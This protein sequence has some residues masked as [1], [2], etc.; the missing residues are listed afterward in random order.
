MAKSPYKMDS[1]ASVSVTVVTV[2]TVLIRN[3]KTRKSRYFTHASVTL[4]KGVFEILESE[5]VLF[6]GVLHNNCDDCHDCLL[7]TPIKTVNSDPLI[8]E[9]AFKKRDAHVK[10]WRKALTKWTPWR[11]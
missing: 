4:F 1:V 2:A 6:K 11:A 8:F 9:N 3:P 10:K 7:K 5:I